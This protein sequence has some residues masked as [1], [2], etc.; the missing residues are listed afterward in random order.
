MGNYVLQSA[1]RRIDAFTPGSTLP[2]LFES[3]FLCAP[4]I[5]DSVFEKGAPMVKLNELCHHISIYHNRGDA[6]LHVSDYTKGNPERL[7]TAG[8]ARPSLL[9]NKVHQIDCSPIV[10]GLVE[11]SYY[12][13]GPVCSDIHQT[14]N[15]E[16]FESTSRH[17]FRHELFSNIWFMK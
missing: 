7:G 13:W 16:A 14:I 5:N 4:D 8:A 15:G 2:R 11:H 10:T 3:I 6:A 12:L 9:H 1:L 17:R